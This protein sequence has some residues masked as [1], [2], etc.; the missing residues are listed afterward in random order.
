M[1]CADSQLFVAIRLGCLDRF[2]DAV[3]R[4]AS[5]S[6]KFWRV[7]TPLEMAYT[8]KRPDFARR[9]IDLGADPHQTRNKRG[10]TLLV[11]AARTGDIGLLIVLL[12]A[13]VDP[14]VKGE[15]ERTALH[16][17]AKQGFDFVAKSLISYKANVDA[18]D[19]H[20][21]APLHLAVHGNPGVVRELLA[22][23]AQTN[24]KNH[25]SYTPA[26]EAAAS[27]EAEIA[28]QILMS[29]RDKRSTADFEDLV[30]QIS[31]VAERHDHAEA[32][33]TIQSLVPE[34][35]TFG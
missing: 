1:K 33:R 13:D 28:K 10:D 6:S 17:A 25:T 5:L 35:A 8:F 15:R 19:N 14:N 20:R 3:Q 22:G 32:S 34:A 16:H 29:E 7:G 18:I 24:A 27:G 26:H 23:Y 4:G 30:R 2:N 21:H 12:D 9:L 11:R 31:N